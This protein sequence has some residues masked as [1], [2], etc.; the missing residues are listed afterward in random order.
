MGIDPGN[1]NARLGESDAFQEA[2]RDADDRLH[3]LAIK[4][5]EELT[6]RNVG[7]DM[8]DLQL[9]GVEHH[10]V[11]AAF[12]Q[13]RQ[14]LGMTRIIV[15]GQMKRFF[16]QRCGRDGVYVA[17][18]RQRR[19]PLHAAV[20]QIARLG[21]HFTR[22]QRVRLGQRLVDDMNHAWSK[23]RLRDLGDRAKGDAFRQP[24][25]LQT[26]QGFQTPDHHQRRAVELVFTKRFD[27]NFRTD[28]RR[29]AHRNRNCF[30]YHCTS[31]Q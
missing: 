1:G 26:F 8:N 9:V 28:A 30:S 5:I 14:Q 17:F 29:V 10:G 3:A 19:R 13:R 4:R 16:I 31:P 7:R 20:G 25:V 12:S 6:Q 11:I 2:I 15:P 24:F 23:S 27:N 22:L 21:L 18:H